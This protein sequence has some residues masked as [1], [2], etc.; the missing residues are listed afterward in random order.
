MLAWLKSGA[1][2]PAGLKLD[3]DR[4]WEMIR[5]LARIG[6]PD[7]QALIQAELAADPSD[8]GRKQSIGARASLPDEG[9]RD[10]WLARIFREPSASPD[11]QFRFAELRDAM[12]GLYSLDQEGLIQKFEDRYFTDIPRLVR[13]SDAQDEEYISALSSAMFPPLCGQE[14]VRKASALLGSESSLPAPVTKSM[15]IRRQDV[16]RCIR[17]RELSASRPAT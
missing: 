14:I 10:R 4:R 7:A 9:E 3:Q 2:A 17:A 15:K 16:E 5:A 6:A 11:T 12:R 8:D 1:G 13:N